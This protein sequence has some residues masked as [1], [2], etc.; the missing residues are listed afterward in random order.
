[1]VESWERV[2]GTVVFGHRAFDHS[3]LQVGSVTIRV[4]VIRNLF[5]NPKCYIQC[6]ILRCGVYQAENSL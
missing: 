2:V 5:V 4:Y 6:E 3:G 1:L